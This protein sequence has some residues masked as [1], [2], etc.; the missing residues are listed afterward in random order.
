MTTTLTTATTTLPGEDAPLE[1]I[2]GRGPITAREALGVQRRM[3]RIEILRARP[4][5]K[6]VVPDELPDEDA[7]RVSSIYRLPPRVMSFA[8]ARAEMEGH[9][10]TGLIESFLREYGAGV[11][12][13][14]QSTREP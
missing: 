11:P 4:N 6:A 1:Y 14:P 2:S 3:A 12:N 10:M 9:T 8:R 7:K 5:S 13:A